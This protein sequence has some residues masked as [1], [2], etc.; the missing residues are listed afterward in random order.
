[1]GRILPRLCVD[2]QR[3]ERGP[4]VKSLNK[5]RKD[6]DVRARQAAALA[7]Y[8]AGRDLAWA[9]TDPAARVR[10]EAALRV[11]AR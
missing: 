8:H 2:G 3:V 4:G 10:R 11:R 5:R 1:M 7:D 9:R 6:P